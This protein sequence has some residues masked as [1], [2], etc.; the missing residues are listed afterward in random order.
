MV[1]SIE[2]V[3]KKFK[4]AGKDISFARTRRITGYLV[5]TLDRFNNAKRAE[6]KDRVKHGCS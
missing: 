5:G 6:E 4:M 1:K 2:H 3:Q